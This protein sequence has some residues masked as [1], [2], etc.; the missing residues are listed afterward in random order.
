MLKTAWEK[1]S[2]VRKETVEASIM[3][4]A[5]TGFALYGVWAAASFQNYGDA[6]IAGALTIGLGG[7]AWSH[8]RESN[9]P[10]PTK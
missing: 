2:N 1:V 9:S 8:F 6:C 5:A 10:S 4:V 7:A 3:G